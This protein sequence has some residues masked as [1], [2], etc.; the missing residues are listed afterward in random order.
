[1]WIFWV[2]INAAISFASHT[3]C[4]MSDFLEMFFFFNH[5]HGWQQF[6]LCS[7]SEMLSQFFFPFLLIKH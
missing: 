1:M 3:L 2:Y 5:F 6:L 7:V 4:G